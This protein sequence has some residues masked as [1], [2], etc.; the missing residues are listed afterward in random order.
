MCK[1]DLTINFIDGWWCVFDAEGNIIDG[2]SCES[3]A[4]FYMKYLE[5]KTNTDVLC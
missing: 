3:D 5:R 1:V 2:F 4:Y